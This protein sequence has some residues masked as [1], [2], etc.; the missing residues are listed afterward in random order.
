MT[1]RFPGCDHPA[2]FADIDHT[3]AYAA[4]GLTH[5]SNLKWLTR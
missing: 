1:C 4:G 3:N 2:E 5:A